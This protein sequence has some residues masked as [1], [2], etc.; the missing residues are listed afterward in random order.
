MNTRMPCSG[1]VLGTFALA[2]IAAG[3]GSD[4]ASP[5]ADASQASTACPN[6]GGTWQV[7]MHCYAGLIG[8]PVMI[9]QDGCSFST[10]GSFG[11]FTGVVQA[12]GS[13]M[14]HGTSSGKSMTCGGV[15]TSKN[16]TE[17]CNTDC[18]VT[19]KR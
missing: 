7:S 15:V 19:L 14:M 12:D 9:A 1:L 4:A 17:T 16:I 5:L 3:C 10:D 8:S 6:L 18:V 11:T 13:F 2:L